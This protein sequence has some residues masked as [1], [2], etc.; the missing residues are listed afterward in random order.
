MLYERGLYRFVCEDGEQLL[1]HEQYLEDLELRERVLDEMRLRLFMGRTIVT[2][3]A[4]YLLQNKAK[5]DIF[6]ELQ[7]AQ[8]ENPLQFFAPSGQGAIDFLNDW[9]SKVLF[10]TAGNRA[11][12]TT[13]A[14]I[15]A[16]IKV[17][18]CDKS[19]PIF[20]EHG[21]DFKTFAAEK[22]LGIASYEWGNHTKTLGPEFF[23]WLPKDLAGPW[24]PRYTGPS[25]RVLTFKDNP[26]LPLTNGSELH[27][28]AYSQGQTPF[29]SEALQGWLWD[30][31]PPEAK[32]DGANERVRNFRDAQH[33]HVLT[34]HGVEGEVE[35]GTDSFL[36]EVY[37]G[38]IKKGYDEKLIRRYRIPQT[39]VPDWILPQESK[40]ESIRQWI[41]EPTENQDWDKLREGESRVMGEWHSVSG[42][43]YPMWNREY[44][45][46]EPFDI[47]ST[48]T[49]FRYVDHGRVN[50]CAALWMAIMKDYGEPILILYREYYKSG[51]IIQ[52]NAEGIIQ[53]SGNIRTQLEP[54]WKHGVPYTRY[55][56]AFINERYRVTKMD[57]RSFAKKSDESIFTT[58]QIYEREGLRCVQCSGMAP[59]NS[60]DLVGR[61]LAVDHEKIN[62][63]TKKKGFTRVLVFSNLTNFIHEIEGYV[64]DVYATRTGR[65]MNKKDTPRA[66]DDHLLDCARWCIIDDPK[67]CPP[68]PL[69]GK[70]IDTR[71]R[72]EKRR[73]HADPYTAY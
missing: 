11:G 66:K 31:Q 24:H 68:M 15:K 34:P 67:Y 44:H 59:I 62:P 25:R 20:T 12:K 55:K 18:Q 4:K 52:E 57:A 5:A 32:W 42:M 19:W 64:Y 9:D 48:A 72:H 39:E 29:E 22:K 36:F 28:Y 65:L 3:S 54:V 6:L 45:V 70:P 63:I 8:E 49:R 16:I 69:D 40:E 56:E 23:K 37:K 13:S 27:F 35:T 17:S 58:G 2:Y 73:L 60:V 21:V 30:E 33:W 43:V 41:T 1:T 7:Q 51:Q 47:P 14:I 53:A 26:V 38:D 71:R 10:I 46:I 50:P 61:W